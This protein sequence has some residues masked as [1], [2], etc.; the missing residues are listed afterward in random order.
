MLPSPIL[1]LAEHVSVGQNCFDAS[2][3]SVVFCICYRMPMDACFFKSSFPFHRLVGS[4]PHTYIAQERIR[5]MN[6]NLHED[7]T[8]REAN[9]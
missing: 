5:L 8:V 9:R 4:Y 6:L 2:I 3:G 7:Q 1:P